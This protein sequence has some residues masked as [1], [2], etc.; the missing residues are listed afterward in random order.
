[1][2][3]HV[4][5]LRK[6]CSGKRCALESLRNL[7]ES[8]SNDEVRLTKATQYNCGYAVPFPVTEGKTTLCMHILFEQHMHTH[9]HQKHVARGG[10]HVSRRLKDL[11]VHLISA[12]TREHCSLVVLDFEKLDSNNQLK[13][14]YHQLMGSPK[15]PNIWLTSVAVLISFCARFWWRFGFLIWASPNIVRV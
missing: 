4:Q 12:E 9:M 15:V 13:A 3:Y 1:M 7:W 6:L 10:K 11:L 8:F 14:S 2:V 5:D